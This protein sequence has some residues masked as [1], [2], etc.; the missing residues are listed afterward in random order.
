MPHPSEVNTAKFQV[1]KILYSTDGFS[2]A[3]GC[4]EDKNRYLA[5]R[6]DGE[7]NKIGFPQTYGKPQ[8]LIIP[9]K[10]T[11]PFLKALLDTDEKTRK[12]PLIDLLGSLIT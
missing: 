4:W 8:W 5:V 1:E 10:L 2:I 12:Q 9:D 3:Y 7:E 11:T 6:W